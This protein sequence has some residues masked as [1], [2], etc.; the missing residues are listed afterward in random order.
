[1]KTGKLTACVCCAGLV[2]LSGC[3]ADNG[4]EALNTAAGSASA[5]TNIT[6]TVQ[7]AAS[8]I[9]QSTSTVSYTHL[10]WDTCKDENLIHLDIWRRSWANIQNEK[11]TPAPTD[12]APADNYNTQAYSYYANWF[13]YCQ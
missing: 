11:N 2:L 13:M 8:S 4:Q 10:P 9:L 7:P 5:D 3:A 12:R 6:A 1:M